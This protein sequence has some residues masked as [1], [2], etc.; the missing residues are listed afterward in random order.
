MDFDTKPDNFTR[1]EEDIVRDEE[2]VMVDAVNA[3]GRPTIS[4][5]RDKGNPTEAPEQKP[6]RR[7]HTRGRTILWWTVCIVAVVL[8]AAFWIRYFN[9][10]SVGAQERGYIIGLECRGFI[11]KTWEGEMVVKEALTDSTRP[12]MRDFAFSVEESHVARELMHYKNSRQEVVVTYKRYLGTIPSRGEHKYVV[13]AVKAVSDNDS[14]PLHAPV[15][16]E[17]DPPAVEELT[18]PQPP[19]ASTEVYRADEPQSAP[20]PIHIEEP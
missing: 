3:D 1:D 2:K 8:V 18:S 12:Y 14:T 19:S 13:T 20:S 17:T 10:Y 15:I 4:F 6:T 5:N 7:R 11:F 9:P 16:K